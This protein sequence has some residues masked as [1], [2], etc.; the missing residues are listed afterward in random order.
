MT[1]ESMVE[2]LRVGVMSGFS[3]VVLV[4]AVT[5]FLGVLV[6]VFENSAG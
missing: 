3:L 1:P 2:V 4:G 6:G 5:V